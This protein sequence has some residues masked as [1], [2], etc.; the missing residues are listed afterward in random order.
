M[1]IIF[2]TTLVFCSKLQRLINKMSGIDIY[3]MIPV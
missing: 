3:N 1:N 2:E